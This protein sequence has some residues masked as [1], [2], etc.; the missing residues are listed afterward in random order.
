MMKIKI[1]STL[2][3]ILNVFV[4]KSQTVDYSKIAIEVEKVAIDIV[5]NKSLL[6]NSLKD[7]VA[8][9]NIQPLFTEGDIYYRY[10]KRFKNEFSFFQENIQFFIEKYF[11]EK[12]MKVKDWGNIFPELRKE[13]KSDFKIAFRIKDLK[14]GYNMT[15]RRF[16]RPFDGA[17][18]ITTAEFSFFL[19]YLE[20]EVLLLN[21]QNNTIVYDKKLVSKYNFFER[22]SFDDINRFELEQYNPDFTFLTKLIIEKSIDDLLADG[23]FIKVLES[24][25]EP[26]NIS[27]DSEIVLKNSSVN[28]NKNLKNHV[29]SSVTIAVGDVH[30][31][32][33]FVS[34]DGMI[35]TC[36]HV[37]KNNE[38]VDVILNNGIKLSGKVIRKNEN[39]D[40]ALIKVD[41]V[42]TNPIKIG[43]SEKSETGEELFAIGSP[44][45][46]DLGQSVSKGILSGKRVIDEKNY[47]Q[48]DASVSPGNS[49]GPLINKNGEIIGIINAKIVGG[50]SEGIGFAIPSNVILE[51]LKL[52]LQ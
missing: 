45:F 43:N 27:F 40:L 47:L 17:G 41:G 29:E 51:Q 22:K 50:G 32:G 38:T 20:F 11:N 46:K 4:L 33:A 36:N 24:K 34:N 26:Q 12:K 13:E 21:T 30:G 18:L 15:D 37:L 23:D 39:F 10:N 48:T 7:Y 1:V 16:N 14:G 2:A 6:I 5:D 49:G 42:T 31:S 3:L 44:S 28:P 8:Y 9:K 19:S 25:S 35:L 52:K